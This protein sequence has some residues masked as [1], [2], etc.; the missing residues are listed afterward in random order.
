MRPRSMTAA[1]R[2]LPLLC[3]LVLAACAPLLGAC[4]DSA[5]DVVSMGLF[6]GLAAMFV[7]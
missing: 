2:L 5:T 4:D 6:L 7:A 1:A 3:A